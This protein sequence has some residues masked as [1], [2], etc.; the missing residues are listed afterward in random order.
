MDKNKPNSSEEKKNSSREKQH[1]QNQIENDEKVENLLR[2][3][4]SDGE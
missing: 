2:K 4:E 3:D 1:G